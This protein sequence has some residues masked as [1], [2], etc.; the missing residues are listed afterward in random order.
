MLDRFTYVG[1][2]P[3]H[4]V[5]LDA[6]ELVGTDLADASPTGSVQKRSA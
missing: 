2:Q 6:V 5:A 1:R 3:V 4:Q